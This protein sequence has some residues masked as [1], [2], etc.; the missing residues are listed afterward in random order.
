MGILRSFAVSLAMA[1][2]LIA[3]AANMTPIAITGF[4][5]DM[6]IENNASG[7]PYGTAALEFNPGENTAFFQNGLAG[8]TYG[9]PTTGSFTSAVGD[10]T[11]FQ[12][13]PYTGSNALVL[14]SETGITSGTL[15]LTSPTIYLRIAVI[16]NS[17]NGGG[18]PN[19]TLHFSDSSTFVTNYNAQDWFFNPGFA[20]QG[21][22]RINLNS[23]TPQG[24]PNDPRFYQTTID[25]DALFGST[26]KSLTSL[27]FEM[28]AANS[29]G[30]YSVSGLAASV[31][32]NY[33]V[34]TITNLPAT[35]I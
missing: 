33:N 14:S 22:D 3:H 7:P 15:T 9:L 5:R 4:N 6:V 34:A 23:G 35:S 17:G 20:L 8:T 27:T 29:T 28:A 31:G 19:V 13:Q 11:V 1:L 21:V 25:L 30:V 18:T 2:P 10:G 32:T 26:N 12:F 24:G 16:A